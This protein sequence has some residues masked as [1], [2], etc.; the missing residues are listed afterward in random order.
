MPYQCSLL[1]SVVG[2]EK[3]NMAGIGNW[4]IVG[5][6]WLKE[7][8][9]KNLD[10]RDSL[11]LSASCADRQAPRI[12]SDLNV[13]TSLWVRNEQQVPCRES[14]QNLST[15]TK[16]EYCGLGSSHT[17][18][19]SLLTMLLLADILFLFLHSTHAEPCYVLDRQ[20]RK[21]SPPLGWGMKIDI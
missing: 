5:Y 2:G 13:L 19:D 15:P 18:H 7:E 20:Q 17:L 11:C 16:M 6:L 9:R 14:G 10:A 12:V 21:N 8:K 1:A 3:K 4:K